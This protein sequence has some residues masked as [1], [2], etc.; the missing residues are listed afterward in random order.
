MCTQVFIQF[1]TNEFAVWDAL[2]C[3]LN[4]CRTRVSKFD[5]SESYQIGCKPFPTYFAAVRVFS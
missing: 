5:F 4:I 3:P 1:C 2:S